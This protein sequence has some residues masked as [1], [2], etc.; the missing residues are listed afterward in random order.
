[1]LRVCR[2]R[3]RLVVESSETNFFAFDTNARDPLASVSIY[4]WESARLLPAKILKV[5][6]SRNESQILAPIIQSV[7]I[8]VV[9]DHVARRFGQYAVHILVGAIDP[10]GRVKCS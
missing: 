7:P 8:Y 5:L 2:S 9:N 10:S 1:M 3:L 4:A 6:S